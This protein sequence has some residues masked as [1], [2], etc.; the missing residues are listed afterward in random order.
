MFTLLHAHSPV[1]HESHSHVDSRGSSSRLCRPL[2]K[3]PIAISPM[4]ALAHFSC[5]HSTPLTLTSSSSIPSS[6]TT[7]Q[8]TLPINKHCAAPPIEESGPLAN[9]TS[10]TKSK[11]PLCDGNTR[12]GE[13]ISAE[14]LTAIG[15]IFDLKKQKMTQEFSRTFGPFKVISFIV[16]ILNREFNCSCQKKSHSRFH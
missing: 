12:E 7:F 15:K 14:N 9:T 11:N 1:T 8:V 2:K 10:S 5:S 16:I 4:F 13:R 6:R 3:S